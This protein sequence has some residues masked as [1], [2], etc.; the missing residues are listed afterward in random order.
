VPMCAPLSWP[1]GPV[2]RSAPPHHRVRLAEILVGREVGTARSIPRSSASYVLAEWC[3]T[4]LRTTG[5]NPLTSREARALQRVK[6]NVYMPIAD[7]GNT[8][9]T[10]TSARNAGAIQTA[11]AS[12]F[13]P[14]ATECARRS[15]FSAASRSPYDSTRPRPWA[16]HQPAELTHLALLDQGASLRSGGGACPRCAAGRAASCAEP[17]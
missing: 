7:V 12:A 15:S 3:A 6:P 4:R 16:R 10:V 2:V 5:E 8:A 13:R 9:A 11:A 17:P 14:T 1:R